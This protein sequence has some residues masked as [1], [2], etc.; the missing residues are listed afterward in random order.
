M[1]MMLLD[2]K[3]M[4]RNVY[5]NLKNSIISNIYCAEKCFLSD[6]QTAVDKS[7]NSRVKL[8]KASCRYEQAA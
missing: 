6:I 8:K 5:L 1:T 3:N 7:E 4:A 2:E